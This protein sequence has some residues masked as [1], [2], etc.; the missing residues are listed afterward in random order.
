M[1]P[2][3]LIPN[4]VTAS[5]AL[6]FGG[7]LNGYESGC[8]G[9]I[10]H[11][12]QF[13]AD[14]GPMSSTVVGI[15]V[16]MI[17]L[18]GIA[19]ALFAGRLADK[20]GRLRIMMPGAALFG[21]GALLQAASFSLGQFIFGRAV[22]GFGQGMFL[23][24]IAVYISEIAPSR[25]R[26]R[27]T[28]LPQFMATLG[29]CIGYFTGYTTSFI[30][31]SAAWRLPYVIQ[32]L[33][34]AMLAISCRSLPES[35]RWLILQG[36]TQE[37][38]TALRLLDF[39]MDEARRDFLDT[40][41]EQ[42]SLSNRQTLLLPFRGPYRYRTILALFFLSMIQLSGIDAIVYYAPALFEQA[43]ISQSSSSLVA[44]GVSSIAM[45][46]ISIPAFILADKWGRR[47]SAIGGGLCL[48][49]LMAL[50]GS[51][52]AA[53]I[54]STV[55][56]VRWVVI[57]SVVLFGMT[58]CATW[59]IV[60]KIYA[61]EIQPGNTRAAGNSISMASSFVSP[62]SAK[63]CNWL[64]ALITPILLGASAYGAYYL[65]GGLTIFTSIVLALFM[66]ETRGRSL[67]N[68]QSEFRRP[69]LGVFRHLRIPGGPRAPADQWQ[70]G[71]EGDPVELAARTQE[72]AA[73]SSSGIAA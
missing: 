57:L 66:P 52:Y 16:S 28:S 8:I 11:M 4:Y 43:G 26:G 49:G 64:V 67:E 15:T 30:E 20:S 71:Q 33:L 29:I 48:S 6:S 13:S 59:N 32:I 55:G 51:L 25:R 50:I 47:T 62:D 37:A 38:M 10:A 18:T 68:I 23:P 53:D 70:A 12:E 72:T 44:S 35:P 7:L 45:F 54:V 22:T 19:P 60:A 73:A 42:P 9:S 40:P 36:R 1:P 27:L 41:Q 31:S 46:L 39:D 21:I 3:K 24:N 65:F 69:V 63:F 17:L 2:G 58:Y 14:I 5:I 56:A 34:S 61:S